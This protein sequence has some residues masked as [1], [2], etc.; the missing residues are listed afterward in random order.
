MLEFDQTGHD[1]W[2]NVISP[3]DDVCLTQLIKRDGKWGAQLFVFR[4]ENSDF[5]R[6]IADK[7]DEL[8]RM[9]K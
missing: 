6:Q 1:D 9:K 2:V 7:L 8:N 5:L 4:I 3:K